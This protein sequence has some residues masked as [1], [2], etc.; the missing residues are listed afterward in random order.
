IR[1]WP[2]K[3]EQKCTTTTGYR[4]Q[5]SGYRLTAGFGLWALG[6][7]LWALGF[8]LWALG[9]GVWALGYRLQAAALGRGFSILADELAVGAKQ[10]E[11][12]TIEF[13]TDALFALEDHLGTL[14]LDLPRQ[15]RHGHG[16]PHAHFGFAGG[17]TRR[18]FRPRVPIDPLGLGNP[19]F[20]I[21]P[22]WTRTTS[23]HPDAELPSPRRRAP[24]SH[25]S[26]AGGA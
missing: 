15:H 19:I 23:G 26:F 17:G 3:A 18:V 9:F 14:S 10:I 4:L 20:P 11:H 25:P 5:A 21:R 2:N 13:P 24:S 22:R 12:G 8:G 16:G 7:G 1:Q 6:F